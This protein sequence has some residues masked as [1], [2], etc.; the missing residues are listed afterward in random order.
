[1]FELFFRC[2][3]HLYWVFILKY[4]L[5]VMLIKL[6]IVFLGWMLDS[7]EYVIFLKYMWQFHLEI[8]SNYL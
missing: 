1:M 4:D 7:K 3:H 8:F 2:V 6:G 5:V